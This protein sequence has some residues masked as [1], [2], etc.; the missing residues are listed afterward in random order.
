M[1]F[2]VRPIAAQNASQD[3]D[4]TQRHGVLGSSSM[5]MSTRSLMSMPHLL[6]CLNR[7]DLSRLAYFPARRRLLP[8]GVWL[9]AL[10]PRALDGPL[11]R[12]SEIAALLGAERAGDGQAAPGQA[13]AHARVVLAGELDGDGGKGGW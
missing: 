10:R 7:R 6:A 5:A 9:I 11:E 13:Q 2:G 1:T 4:G 3:A 8:A 12:R